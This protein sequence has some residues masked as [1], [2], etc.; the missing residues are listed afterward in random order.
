M[1][2]KFKI[3]E[4]E[5][6]LIATSTKDFETNYYYN[7]FDK[8]LRIGTVRQPYHKS[9]VGYYSKDNSLKVY[10]PLLPMLPE[11]VVEDDEA[12]KAAALAFPLTE[13]K[14]KWGFEE[15]VQQ[16]NQRAF[17]EGY[18]A[19][20]K[21]YSEDDLRK[22]F[23]SGMDYQEGGV[24]L[25]P[26]EEGYIQSLKQPKTT[27]KWFVAEMEYIHDDSV[28]YLKTKGERLKTTTINNKAYLIGHYE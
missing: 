6:Y 4:T 11:I 2:T 14:G 13:I 17:I 27:P 22:A 20:T 19:A 18:K 24:I 10:L 7:E 28:P 8:D 21:V 26:D 9:V 16:F 5:N 3:I 23:K 25:Y 15:E 12:S 1:E